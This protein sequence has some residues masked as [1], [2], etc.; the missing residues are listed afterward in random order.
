[1]IAPQPLGD[2]MLRA[3]EGKSVT[4]GGTSPDSAIID[5]IYDTGI[6]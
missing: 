1:M 4:I 5:F 3:P 6:R 2:H